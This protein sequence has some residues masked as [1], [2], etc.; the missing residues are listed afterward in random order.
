VLEAMRGAGVRKAYIV[1]REGKW[2]IPAYLGDGHLADMHLAY[3]MMRQSFGVPFTLDQ[4]YPFVSECLVALGFPDILFRPLD[5]FV[6][7]VEKQAATGAD[8]VLGV[9]PVSQ[10]QKMDLVDLDAKGRVR[11]IVIKPDQT[12]LRYAWVNAVWAPAFTDFLHRYVQDLERAFTVGASFD[13]PEPFVG[14]AFQAAIDA[15]LL[16]DAVVFESGTYVDI[17][18]PEDLEGAARKY[19]GEEHEQGEKW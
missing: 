8:V 17:G 2:D 6:S 9:F 11:S 3:V 10:P 16:V 14:E 5:G 7:L 1:L 19:L 15:G 18:T 13:G 12:N 4:A